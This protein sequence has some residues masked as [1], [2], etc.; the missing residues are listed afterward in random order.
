MSEPITRKRAKGRA[1]RPFKQGD[2][3]ALCGVYSIVNAVRALC[4]E[5]GRAAATELFDHLMRSLRK[6]GANAATAVGG[7][8]YHQ[9]VARLA[10][11]ATAYVGKHHGVALALEPMPKPKLT[12]RD[13]T[14]FWH[15]LSQTLTPERVA[16]LALDGRHDH[17]TVAVAATRTRLL[18]FDSVGMRWLRRSHCAV[19][20][21]SRRVTIISRRVI[22]IARRGTEA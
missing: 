11:H 20:R 15:T 2:L 5:V 12:G 13:L 16:I 17:W 6:V 19:G 1:R 22:V 8:I 4:P 21:A 9:E 7:G 14:G 10:R 3:D 18:L